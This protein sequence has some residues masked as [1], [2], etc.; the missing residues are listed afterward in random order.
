MLNGHP[1]DFR[2]GST[3]TVR[4]TWGPSLAVFLI[5]VLLLIAIYQDA[6]GVAVDVWSSSTTYNHAFAILPVVGYLIWL[7]WDAVSRLVPK[8][9]LWGLGFLLAGSLIWLVGRET[10]AE[11]IQQFAIVAMIQALVLGLFGWPIVRAIL[12]PLFYLYFAVPFGDFLVPWLQ[13]LT[14]VSVVTGLQLIG[15]PVFIDGILI[16]T[17]NGVFE[18]AE[19][20]AGL[21]FL[22]ATVALGA[23]CANLLYR[24]WWRRVVFIALSILI[25]IVANGFRAFGIVLIA[26]LSNNKLAV[27]VDHIVYG[28][29]FFAFVTIVLLAVGMV[30][31]DKDLHET[32]DVQPQP[33]PIATSGRR[34]RSALT[35]GLVAI[36]ALAAGPGLAHYGESQSRSAEIAGLSLPDVTPPWTRVDGDAAVWRPDYKG[37]DAATRQRY[38]AGERNAE[39]YVAYYA[40]QRAGAELVYWGNRV[41]EEATW[42]R[43]GGGKADLIVDG[44]SERVNYTRVAS[45]GRQRIVYHWYWVDDQFAD[46]DYFAKLL[47][48]R[49]RLLG[50]TRASAAILLSVPY[51]DDLREAKVTADELLASMA[52]L[53]PLLR[54][55]APE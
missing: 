16:M 30:F 1:E 43:L 19:A 52:P 51:D 13:D 9:S 4:E 55:A 27:G 41:Y 35:I 20:C 28:W 38:T 44:S 37:A 40:Y 7:R 42:D 45:R 2:T 26:H 18:V 49:A 15:I 54:A 11:V 10:Q 46:A 12:F 32:I 14:A 17:P 31:R 5:A 53:A 33:G 6:I 48:A 24:S 39:L 29:L 8:P 3:S 50:G 34:L 36:F 23:L 21:R 25:P 22:I 47:A